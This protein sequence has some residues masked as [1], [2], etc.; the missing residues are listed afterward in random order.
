M[1]FPLSVT[2]N[3]ARRPLLSCGDEWLR[4]DCRNDDSHVEPWACQRLSQCPQ[5]DDNIIQSCR[6]YLNKDVASLNSDKLG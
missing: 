2:V 6:G 1:E 4:S 5:Y 3:A